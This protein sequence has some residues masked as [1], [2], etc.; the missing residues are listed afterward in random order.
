MQHIRLT[1]PDL[2]FWVDLTVHERDGRCLATADEAEDSRD[3]A[4]SQRLE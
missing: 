1:H 4:P 2:D 3:V